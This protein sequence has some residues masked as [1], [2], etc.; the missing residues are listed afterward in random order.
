MAPPIID[1]II[2]QKLSAMLK[3]YTQSFAY[4][5][6]IIFEI[7]IENK[8]TFLKMFLCFEKLSH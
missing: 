4:D 8:V 2:P 6:Y 7:A 3:I 1:Y 5:K